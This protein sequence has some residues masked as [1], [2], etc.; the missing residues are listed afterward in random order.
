MGKRE[1]G[2]GVERDGKGERVEGGQSREV[3]GVPKRRG[4]HV[5]AMSCTKLTSTTVLLEV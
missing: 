4:Y 5:G 1:M 2:T 3:K